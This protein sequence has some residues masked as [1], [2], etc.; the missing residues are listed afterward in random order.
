MAMR[1]IWV[2]AL[3]EYLASVRSK[4][5]VVGIVL[6]P[7][8]MS[9][10]MVAQVLFKDQG[11]LTPKRFAIVDRTPGQQF[12]A[13]L[14]AA[15]DARNRQVAGE[16]GTTPTQAAFIV[17]SIAAEPDMDALRFRLSE[18]VRGGE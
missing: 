16:G 13:G 1:K 5:F 4:S 3:R 18:R 11:D 14:E 15:A 8:L 10:A 7:V 17:E 9:G 6:M 2:I 12:L